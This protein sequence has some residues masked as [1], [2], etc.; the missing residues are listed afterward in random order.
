[1]CDFSL[2]HYQEILDLAKSQGYAFKSFL[3]KPSFNTVY[4]RHDIDLSLEKALDFAKIEKERGIKATYFLQTDGPFYNVFDKEGL[5]IMN[6]I[7]Y[8]GHEIGLHYNKGNMQK[9]VKALNIKKLVSFHRSPK[10]FLGKKIKGF[11]SACEPRFFQEI[12]YVSESNNF[13]REGCVCQ[14]LKEKKFP[15][16]QILVHPIWWQNSFNNS[17]DLL[18]DYLK[19]YPEERQEE[20]R[21]YLR[22]NIKSYSS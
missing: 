13:W 21:D 11:V 2:E 9:Q 3:E 6:Q 20:L 16:I 1:M 8:L 15:Q 17:T 10:E 14:I 12:K 7:Y 5:A 18:N 19:K 4:L 22:K